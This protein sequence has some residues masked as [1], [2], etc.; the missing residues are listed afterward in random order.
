[1]R[2]LSYWSHKTLESNMSLK[3]KLWLKMVNG[4]IVQKK[5]YAG[6]HEELKDALGLL[7]FQGMENAASLLE[8][9][10]R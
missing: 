1:M 6:L 4:K 5:V 3:S 10:V 2:S 7:R 8:K 9:S